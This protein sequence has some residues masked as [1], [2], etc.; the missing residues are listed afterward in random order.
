MKQLANVSRHG[1]QPTKMAD[2]VFP[3]IKVKLTGLNGN[4]FGLLGAVTKAM[5]KNGIAPESIKAFTDEA[6]EGNYDHLLRTCMR[7]VD[8]E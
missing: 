1:R 7:W 8:V 4:A 2:K 6:M 5:K 3:Q